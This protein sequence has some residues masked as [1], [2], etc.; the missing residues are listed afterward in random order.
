MSSKHDI[1]STFVG[2]IDA[3]ADAAYRAVV[4]LDPMDS[5]T[6]RLSA[7]GLEDHAV[8]AESSDASG[9]LEVAGRRELRFDLVWR[10]DVGLHARLT[11]RVRLDEDG[12]GR[13]LLSMTLAGRG[14]DP[15]SRD[16]LLASWP[17][18]ETLVAAQ[19]R[20]LRRAVD[21]Y[22][23]ELVESEA[24]RLRVVGGAAGTLRQRC[25]PVAQS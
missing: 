4:R 6:T 25:L 22:L 15:P 11:W 3:P 20:S 12:S 19:S 7:L 24:P 9:L 18:I 10:F 21:D 1:T 16:R 17:L 14:N 2:V 23:E 8:W 5:I 13:T